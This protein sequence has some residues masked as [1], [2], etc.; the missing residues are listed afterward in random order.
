MLAA[1]PTPT[2]RDP[3]DTTA[4]IETPEQVRFR[5]Q[6]AGPARRAA[7]WTVDLVVRGCVLFLFAIVAALG[8]LDEK[9]LGGVGLGV[10]LV[11]FFALEWGYY[12]LCE[13]LWDGRSIGKRA[14]RLRVV[15]QDG[16]P[17]GFA[18]SVL[19]NLLRAADWLPMF[20]A[21]GALVMAGDRLFRRLGDLVA[22]TLVVS[23]ER[24]RIG[25]SLQI[26]PA[27]SAKELARIPSRVALEPGDV[28]AIELL[29]RRHGQLS[30]VRELEL[31]EIVAPVFARRMSLRY[32]DAARFLALLY[33]RATRRG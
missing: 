13:T 29:L 26:E 12:V 27:P 19:R 8:G 18:D 9:G 32:R 3:L 15:K 20:Y 23:E 24:Q 2:E 33:H 16:T 11:V 6:L 30:P 7:A 14:L 1:A 21:I 28:E 10:L 17:L 31:A 22:G 5:H 4:E 25:E